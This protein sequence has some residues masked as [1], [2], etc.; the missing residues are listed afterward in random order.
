MQTVPNPSKYFVTQWHK[1][2]FAGM[3]YSFIASG[4]SGET[5]D[6]LAECIDEKIFFAGEV[7]TLRFSRIS[8]FVFGEQ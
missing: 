2:E 4:A 7:S 1:D 6:V 8:N 3:S 5:Y